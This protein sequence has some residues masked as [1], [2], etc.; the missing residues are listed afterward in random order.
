[1]AG[2]PGVVRAAALAAEEGAAERFSGAVR[3]AAVPGPKAPGRTTDLVDVVVV[4]FQDGGRTHWHTHGDEEVLHAIEG[5][6]FLA[7]EDLSLIH[8]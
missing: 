4:S 1:M 3:L 6:G 5:E 7:F 2:R 8:I